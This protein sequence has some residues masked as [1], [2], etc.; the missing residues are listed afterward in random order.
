M[1]QSY[2]IDDILII[3]DSF[4]A[5]RNLHTDWPLA[6]VRQLTNDSSIAS[7]RGKG[8][9]GASWWSARTCLLH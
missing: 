2:T 4:A 9:S 5:G 1:T 8:F 7:V 3:G 6:L